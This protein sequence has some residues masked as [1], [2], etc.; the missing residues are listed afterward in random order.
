[1]GGI[2]CVIYF[3]FLSFVI[4]TVIAFNLG[5]M[6][7]FIKIPSYIV[8]EEKVTPLFSIV[9]FLTAMALSYWIIYA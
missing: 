2:L 3:L 9:A 8:K 4:M 5:F 6:S 1:M 7:Y